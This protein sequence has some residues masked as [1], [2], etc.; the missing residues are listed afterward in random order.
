MDGSDLIHP[1]DQTL[2]AYG[3]G[4]LY[5]SLAESVHSHLSDCGE[6]RQRVAGLSADTFLGK[7]RDAQ[8]RPESPAPIGL[9]MIEENL[10]SIKKPPAG[11]PPQDLVD[12]PDYEILGEL[13]SGGMGVVY[14]AWNKLMARKE[15]LKVVS[16]DLMHRRRILDRFLREIRNAAQLHHPNIVTAYSAIRAGE[17]IVFAMEYVEGHDLDQL[18]KRNGRLPVAHAC[19]FIY[20]AALGLQYAHEKGMVHRDIKPS[21]LIL[22]RHGKKPVVKILDFGLAKANREGSLDKSLTHEGQMLGTPDYIAPEQSLDA[23][24]ADIRAD[25]YSLGCTLYYLLS[26]SPPFSGA[27]LYEVLRGHHSL[28]PT[29]LNVLRADVPTDLAVVIAKMMAKDPAWRYQTPIEVAQA[30]KPF[31]KASEADPTV[32]NPQKSLAGKPSAGLR[33]KRPRSRP[34]TQLPP[35]SVSTRKPE[36]TQAGPSRRHMI[37]SEDVEPLPAIAKSIGVDRGWRRSPWLMPAAI[38]CLLFGL[39]ILWATGVFKG[40]NKNAVLVLEKLPANAVVEFDGERVVVAP[41]TGEPWK[42]DTEPGKHAVIVK[43]GKEVLL[44]ESVTLEPRRE[45]KLSVPVKGL[46]VKQLPEI[47]SSS[48]VSA[49][50]PAPAQQPASGWKSPS[51]GITFVRLEGGDFMMGSPDDDKDAADDEKPQHKV[52]ISPFHMG[53]ADVTQEQYKVVMGNNP[54]WF[55]LTGGGK[56]KVGSQLTD[57]FPVENVSWLDAIKFCNTL[58]EKDGLKAYYHIAGDD[59]WLNLNASGYRLPTEA[60]WEYACRAGKTTK[61]SFGDDPSK[62]GDYAWYSGNSGDHT[63]LVGQKRPNGFGLYDMHGNVWEWCWDGYDEAYYKR[64]PEAAPRGESGA[65]NR[66]VRGGGWDEQPRDCWSAN[67]FWYRPDCR[68]GALGFRLALI[69]STAISDQSASTRAGTRQPPDAASPPQSNVL[70]PRPLA[71]AEPTSSQRTSVAWT[72]RST[73]MILVRIDGG[74][75]MMGSPDDD[76]EAD[77]SRSPSTVYEST[78]FTWARRR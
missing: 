6:C 1:T 35:Q 53:V 3:V 56:D 42:I 57:R 58:S 4:K 13:G 59:V 32:S 36:S 74:E 28:E 5:G 73:S 43:E 41:V 25:I 24:K 37:E 62:L 30:L 20:Q 18:V 71:S 26:G 29:P 64:S 8:A 55:S 47:T 39:S 50:Q 40:K 14:L 52:R 46:P 33:E 49:V 21:N 78:R 38:V 70:N 7:L 60:E 12:H 48:P 65:S 69:E 66:V 72:S 19:N 75:F 61:Y 31:F 45:L 16:S 67:R 10:D 68:D 54:S 22:S 63:H 34:L 76:K 77:R 2:R 17:S 9:S 15:V 27:S 44:A 11:S 23:Q 51:T